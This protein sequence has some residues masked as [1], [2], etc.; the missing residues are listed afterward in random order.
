M[1]ASGCKRAPTYVAKKPVGGR[2]G[3]IAGRL[4]CSECDKIAFF[5]Q[6][7]AT[8]AAKSVNARRVKAASRKRSVVR[9]RLLAVYRGDCGF[10][11][12]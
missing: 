10:G 11:G 9:P 8:T 6:D 1:S 4:C 3:H 2:W 5:S 7:A 12:T